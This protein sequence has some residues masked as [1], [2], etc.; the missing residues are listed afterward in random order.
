MEQDAEMARKELAQLKISATQSPVEKQQ[1][2]YQAAETQR[3]SSWQSGLMEKTIENFGGISETV[4]LNL[5]FDGVPK[6]IEVPVKM[7]LSAKDKEFFKEF[8]GT[9]LPYWQDATADS[10]GVEFISE[11]IKGAYVKNNL[12]GI[13]QGF[14]NKL[15]SVVN[16]NN[17]KY[18]HNETP[19][20]NGAVASTTGG[21][22]SD[23][24]LANELL[25]Y[26]R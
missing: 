25:S 5:S 4:K 17:K 20:R 22:Q 7:N 13:L 10:K 1:V 9:N 19:P 26:I 11:V 6:E 8:I 12:N 21:S 15:T 23:K 3:L 18:L 14:A 16:E 2:D 24:E